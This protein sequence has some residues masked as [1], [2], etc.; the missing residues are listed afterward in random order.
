MIATFHPVGPATPHAFA[1]LRAL[2]PKRA[3][4]GW[5]MQIG[6]PKHAPPAP[7]PQLAQAQMQERKRRARRSLSKRGVKGFLLAVQGAPLTQ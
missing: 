5:V 6:Q 2:L 4:P 3:R 1:G 7:S